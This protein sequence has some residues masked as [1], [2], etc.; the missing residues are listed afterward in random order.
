MRNPRILN[1]PMF[2]RN[3]SAYGRGIT[4]NLVSEEERQ[5][6]N[7]GGRVGASNGVYIEPEIASYDIQ[8]TISD[9]EEGGNELTYTPWSNVWSDYIKPG[10]KT[11]TDV[12]KKGLHPSYGDVLGQDAEGEDVIYEDPLADA[13]KKYAQKKAKEERTAQGKRD[14]TKAREL[15]TSDE[16]MRGTGVSPLRKVDDP[17]ATQ[18][19]LD[20]D[21]LFTDE[22]QK[23][24]KSQMA[25]AI[26]GRLIGGSRDKWGS[27]AQME[28]IKGGLEDI[29]KIADPSERREMQAKYEAWGK[30]QKE[31]D[32]D[33]LEHQRKM[34]RDAGFQL[35]DLIVNKGVDRVAAINQVYGTG[36]E[37]VAEFNED[38][39]EKKYNKGKL[40]EGY[41]MFKDGI[42]SIIRDGK[43]EVISEEEI[44]KTSPRQKA[45][46]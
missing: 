30:A 44:I 5:R 15:M 16:A 24:K 9:I 29:R 27:K 36:I 40:P 28:N 23:E 12:F 17:A 7:Y 11:V 10:L 34:M 1:R 22:E 39:I 8:D 38:K 3:N 35:E 20:S 33:V 46:T 6:F 18:V 45:K 13:K 32:I 37:K 43:F 42:Y 19:D 14:F 21:Q 31:R 26:A 2:N 25:L 41:I 4:S